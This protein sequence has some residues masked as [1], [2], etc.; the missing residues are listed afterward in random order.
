ML[1]KI[2]LLILIIFLFLISVNFVLADNFLPGPQPIQPPD[3]KIKI[4]GMDNLG[5]IKPAMC[6]YDE[7][8]T[9]YQIPWIANYIGGV[10]KFGVSALALLSVIVIAWGGIVWLTAGGSATQVSKAKDWILGGITGLIL[11]L[12]SYVL[13]VT[14]NPDF[15]NLKPLEVAWLAGEKLPEIE[16]WAAGPT[17]GTYSD[18]R[19]REVIR[20]ASAGSITVNAYEPQTS[21][22]GVR[23]ET[24]NGLLK[25]WQGCDQCQIQ[26]SGGTEG[27][28]HNVGEFS[29]G[30]G[31]K[32]DLSYVSSSTELHN[33][34]LRQIGITNVSNVVY[35]KTYVGADGNKYRLEPNTA[36]H[37]DICFGCP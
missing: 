17:T 34:I 21:L 32:L 15:V 14:I 27:G 6:T 20:M 24:I 25:I 1:K 30:T 8:K 22:N 4:P 12:S 26:I 29:H 10:Y 31:Y 37:W 13:L 19:A 11:G 28:Y 7:T 35:D 9:C 33:Y 18:A 2:T 23:V 36:L 3:I 16:P 5:E